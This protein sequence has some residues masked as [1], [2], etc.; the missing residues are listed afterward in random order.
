MKP[1][2]FFAVLFSNFCLFA[3]EL[4]IECEESYYE[5]CATWQ[6]GNE[7]T[8]EG[9]EISG[10]CEPYNLSIQ[11]GV[12]GTYCDTLEHI[13]TWQVIDNCEDTVSCSATQ[14]LFD[15][16]P[17]VNVASP[18]VGACVDFL[19]F[20]GSYVGYSSL[21]DNIQLSW[22]DCSELA[23]ASNSEILEANVISYNGCGSEVILEIRL[24]DVCGNDSLY[25]IS[26]EPFGEMCTN[27]N[28]CDYGSYGPGW[29]VG[30][31]IGDGV[32]ACCSFPNDWC[33]GEDSL[34]SFYSLLDINCEC[35]R[36]DELCPG[37]F[38]GNGLVNSSDLASFLS[39]FGSSGG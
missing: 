25:I 35:F 8:F 27:P 32:C 11:N 30:D 16:S 9:P 34:G 12:L 18:Y 5:E 19:Y 13:Y 24:S 37:D 17:P 3:Q 7:T 15:A 29:I 10:G 33:Q 1:F 20:G 14:Y 26:G 39:L 22:S 28:A 31:D 23:T 4:Q 2:I 21:P 36:P 38:D 6:L